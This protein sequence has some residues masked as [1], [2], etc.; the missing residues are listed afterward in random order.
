MLA[1][2]LNVVGCASPG[3]LGELPGGSPSGPPEQ[4]AEAV[5]AV[6]LDAAPPPVCGLAEGTACA[7]GGVAPKCCAS[8]R[9]CGSN[10]VHDDVCCESHAGANCYSA[11]GCCTGLSCVGGTCQAPVCGLAEGTACAPAGVAPNCC[12]SGRVCG[13]N[14][15]QKSVC[16]ESVAGADCY[17]TH[18]CCAGMACVGGVCKVPAQH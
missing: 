1:A 9:V 4:T 3:D 15:V 17:S 7:P 8:D 10:G 12:A 18:G 13:N 14:G 5:T 11:S 16:C 2:F 6:P